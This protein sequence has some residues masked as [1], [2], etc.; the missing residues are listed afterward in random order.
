MHSLLRSKIADYFEF[1]AYEVDQKAEHLFA[2]K[3]LQE[4]HSNNEAINVKRRLFIN[5]IKLAESENL[6]KFDSTDPN[7]YNIELEDEDEER[8]DE[9]I[10]EKLFKTFCFVIESE[11]GVAFLNK[12]DATFGYL[13]VIDKY[14]SKKSIE[15]FYE[16]LKFSDNELNDPNSFF[17]LKYKP[18]RDQMNRT[19]VDLKSEL[20]KKDEFI[21]RTTLDCLFSTSTIAINNVI[22]E[23]LKPEAMYLFKYTQRIEF[24]YTSEF[25]FKE[26][27]DT[28]RLFEFNRCNVCMNLTN[29]QITTLD[30]SYFEGL[31]NISELKFEGNDIESIEPMAFIGLSNL[32]KLTL[33]F[34]QLNSIHPENFSGLHS[35]QELSVTGDPITKIDADIFLRLSN[36]Q[37]LNLNY[38]QIVSINSSAFKG[39]AYLQELNLNNNQIDSIQSKMFSMLRN[40]KRLYL[41]YNKIISLD[42]SSFAGLNNLQLLHLNNNHLSLIQM[43]A[44]NGLTSLEELHLNDN[45]IKTVDRTKFNGLP[46][47]KI[48]NIKNNPVTSINIA[49]MTKIQI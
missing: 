42:I 32:K 35:L 37:K 3:L 14:L 5:E 29:Q 6:K 26:I 9:K 38:N 39:L 40:L 2:E 36:L 19:S 13:I 15:C 12:L 31:N 43:A 48:I 16:L 30:S 24:N 4:D 21:I 1:L 47:L 18:I 45:K 25:K 44:F 17:V 28:F 11:I 20:L 41:D 33:F 7:E 27:T 49:S 46:S 34:N 23:S 10:N 22:A 8:F